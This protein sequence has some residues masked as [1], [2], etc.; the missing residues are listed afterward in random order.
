[1]RPFRVGAMMAVLPLLLLALACA[2]AAACGGEDKDFEGF[3]KSVTMTKEVKGDKFEP[4]DATTVFGPNDVIHAVVAIRKAPKGTVFEA[5]WT[6][7]D[8]GDA[9]E[10]GQEI[11]VVEATAEGNRNIDFDLKP[12]SR[13]PVGTY[14]V[15]I[16]VDGAP[17]ERV[18]WTV[19]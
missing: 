11:D 14:S 12:T 19:R 9:A 1:M 17:I 5:R 18:A 15:E 10:P 2:S 13:W 16:S 8:V 4:G 6:V 7:Q 3:I